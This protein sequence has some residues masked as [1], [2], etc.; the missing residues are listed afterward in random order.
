MGVKRMI[1]LVA[2]FLMAASSLGCGGEKDKGINKD[3]DKP[4]AGKKG[5]K[6]T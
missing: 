6:G 4:T 1:L 5:D 2:A 3:L